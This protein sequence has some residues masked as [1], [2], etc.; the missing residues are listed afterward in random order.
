MA[1]ICI[2]CNSKN[3]IK[4]F[5]KTSFLKY[6]LYICTSCGLSFYYAD[7]KDVEKKCD[8]YYNS[9][10]WGS[11]RKNWDAQ[12]KVILPIIKIIRTIKTKP[13]QQMWHHRLMQKHAKSKGKLLDIGCGKGEFMQ[14][15]YQMGYDVFGIEPDRNNVN[16]INKK[17]KRKVCINSIAEK[18]KLKDKYDM[19]YLC[20]VFEHLIRP[21]NFL[22]NIKKNLSEEGMVFIEVPNCENPRIL[23]NS[24]KHHPHVYNFTTKSLKNLFESCGYEILEIGPYSEKNR[25]YVLK[26]FLMALQLNNYRKANDKDGEMLI[27]LAK[28]RR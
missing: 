23:D 18:A 24:I 17:F 2:A 4:L 13:L 26:F 16:L 15:F 20:H 21:D 8:E 25:N 10:Y 11:V 14:F 5:K 28:P 3:S 22:K 12:R 7:D 27:V 9:A 1:K 19:V 6:P